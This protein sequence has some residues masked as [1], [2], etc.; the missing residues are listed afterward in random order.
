MN[1]QNNPLISR[2]N[3][4][5]V[6][7]RSRRNRSQ[8]SQSIA[9]RTLL[10]CWAY[11]LIYIWFAPDGTD[12][13]DA[14]LNSNFD[15]VFVGKPIVS[16]AESR[17]LTNHLN[18]RKPNQVSDSSALPEALYP[19]TYNRCCIPAIMNGTTNPKDVQC[20]GT[21]YNQRAC[22]DPSYPYS[23]QEERDTFGQLVKYE[24]HSLQ[25]NITKQKCLVEPKWLVPNVTWCSKP[26]I[27]ETVYGDTPSPGCSILSDAQGGPWQHVFVFPRAKLAFCGIPKG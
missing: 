3:D 15:S 10:I 2:Q 26:T 27:E 13:Y 21:C 18:A 5:V 12:V 23:S 14:S 22:S 8:N 4:N 20:F 7:N 25:E 9:K 17:H 24:P 19:I 16:G 1:Y 6:L 11:T